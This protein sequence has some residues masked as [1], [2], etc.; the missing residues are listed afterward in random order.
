MSYENPHQKDLQE[1]STIATLTLVELRRLASIGAWALAKLGASKGGTER[2]RKMSPRQQ[3]AAGKK[4]AKARW[5]GKKK[6]KK[7][8]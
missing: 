7:V 5:K 1:L 2:A 3:S 4:A 8:R 6:G